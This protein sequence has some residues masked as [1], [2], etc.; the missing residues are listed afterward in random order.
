MSSEPIVRASNLGKCYKIYDKPSDRLLESLPWQ[1][2][3]HRQFWA[4]R[5]VNF[6][7]TRGQTLGIVGR[8]GSGKSTL[9]QL[10]SGIL[11]AT[12]GSIDTPDRVGALLELGSGF[13]PEFT[14]IENIFLN[15]S[16]LGL[17]QGEVQENLQNILDF[18]NIGDFAE[19]PVKTY[20][21]GMSIRL[22]F[23]VQALLN[24][25]LLIVDEALAVGDELFQKK[26]YA[27]L[28]QL[29]RNGTS[30]LLVTH[31][32]QQI[33]QHCDVAMLLHQGQQVL[34]GSPKLITSAYQ[35]LMS[36]KADEDW[37]AA[38]QSIQSHIDQQNPPVGT[39]SLGDPSKR[40]A[41]AVSYPQ[42]QGCIRQI[43]IRDQQGRATNVI[44]SDEPFTLTFHYEVERDFEGLRFGCHI[45]NGSGLRIT[46]QGYPSEHQPGLQASA[47]RHFSI[48]FSFRSGLQPGTYFVG[49]GFWEEQNPQSYIHRVLDYVALRIEPVGPSNSM[50]FCNLVA[51]DPLLQWQEPA[52][53]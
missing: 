31:N 41:S 3:R 40:P 10:L 2:L 28:E 14:G 35:R 44:A 16:V 12:E 34:W 17:S 36:S 5:N 39:S 27:H 8:N 20:S 33:L 49:G 38:I 1:P 50:G 25:D 51:S 18:A 48:A 32:C 23:A 21:S 42:H 19:Q 13:N 30:I 47:K 7:L 29:K 53:T 52:G 22:A 46:G 4:L 15:A 45:A 6:E 43:K 26:C 11:T 9:L 37:K 24:P